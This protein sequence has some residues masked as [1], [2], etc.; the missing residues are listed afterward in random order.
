MARLYAM[1]FEGGVWTLTREP[2]GVTPLDFRQHFT[3]TFSEDGNTIT[4]VWEAGF[5]GGGWEHDFDLTYR[6]VA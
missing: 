6:K 2:P 5:D 4:D 1:T 3:G